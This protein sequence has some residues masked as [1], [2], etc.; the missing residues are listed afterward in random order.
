MVSK[1][2][3][4][5]LDSPDEIINS[6]KEKIELV[7]RGGGFTIARVTLEAGWSW[8]K[9]VKPQE[10]TDSCQVPHSTLIL[11]GR[12]RTVMDDGT[13]VDSGPGDV[14]IVPPGHNTSVTGDEPCVCIDF[15]GIEEYIKGRRS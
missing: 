10:K 13:V 4:K 9:Y 5:N 3:K 12:V 7:N 11:S 8:E 6:E 14:A 1:L 2:Q 15:S